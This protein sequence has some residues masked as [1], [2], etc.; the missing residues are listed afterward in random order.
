M[1]LEGRLRS[2]LI[3]AVIAAVLRFILMPWLESQSDQIAQLETVSKRLDRSIKLINAEKEIGTHHALVTAKLQ[4]LRQRFP[5]V[6]SVAKFRVEVQQSITGD[7][8][9]AKTTLRSFD[10]V[11]EGALESSGLSFVVARMEFF[12]TLSSLARVQAIV[13]TTR[14]N[15]IVREVRFLGEVPANARD[16]TVGSL[17]VSADF[18]Y[19][20]KTP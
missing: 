8:M 9:T 18:F 14:P 16:D 13:E 4:S 19:R 15:M 2:L 3:V 1:R 6:E 11:G 17:V 20:T 5:E 12:G 10:W 7:S